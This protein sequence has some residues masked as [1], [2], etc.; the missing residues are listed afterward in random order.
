MSGND[1]DFVRMGL[2]ERLATTLGNYASS[3]FG[4]RF[5]SDD[6]LEGLVKIRLANDHKLSRI[7]VSVILAT[8]GVTFF[9]QVSGNIS[10]WGLS[11]PLPAYGVYLFCLYLASSLFVLTAT[12]IDSIIIDRLLNRL[13]Q[14]QG[15]Y[16][17]QLL[18]LS[19]GVSNLWSIAFTPTYFGPRSTWAHKFLHGLFAALLLSTSLALY[20]FPAIILLNKVLEKSWSELPIFAVFMLLMSSLLLLTTLVLGLAF[21][22]RF[23]FNSALLPEPADPFIPENWKELG[24]PRAFDPLEDDEQG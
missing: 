9:Q 14:R 6:Y 12:F 4:A 5:Y 20:A 10:L 17:F 11:L 18:T 2:I 16:Q 23:R 21:L 3:N 7:I 24:D 22:L 1:N 13:G 8:L 15:I 19:F